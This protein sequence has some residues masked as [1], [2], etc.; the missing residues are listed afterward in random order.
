MLENPARVIALRKLRDGVVD[1]LILFVLQFQRDDGQAVQEKDEINLLIGLAEIK[2]R[3]EGDAVFVV[4]FE[5]S[6]MS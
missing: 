6:M 2:V 5:C 1:G 3:A 4:E